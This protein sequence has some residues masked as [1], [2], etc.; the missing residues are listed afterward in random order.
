M[1]PDD[2]TLTPQQY[3]K[4]RA[5][6]KRALTRA[7]A[8]GRFP[9]QVADIMAAAKLVEVEEDILNEDFLAK[10]RRKTSGVLRRATAS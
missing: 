3:S 5:E 10:I 1:R 9:T 8:F 6:A 2:S 4:V 7:D